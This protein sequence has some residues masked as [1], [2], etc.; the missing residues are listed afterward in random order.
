MIR[1]A[2]ERYAATGCP[3]DAEMARSVEASARELLGVFQELKRPMWRPNQKALKR[4]ATRNCV[5][6]DPDA[7]ILRQVQGFG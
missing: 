1:D 6:L 2:W 3:R 5:R 4:R 7:L